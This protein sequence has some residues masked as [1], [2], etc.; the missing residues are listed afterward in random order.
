MKLA[1]SKVLQF[2]NFLEYLLSKFSFS[3]PNYHIE[4]IL[5]L[6]LD[7]IVKLDHLLERFHCDVFL[8]KHFR[9]ECLRT[10]QGCWIFLIIDS[11]LKECVIALSVASGHLDLSNPCSICHVTDAT[12]VHLIDKKLWVF[13]SRYECLT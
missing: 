2:H 1:E 13:H 5:E 12:C 9:N 3:C 11:V 7:I 10:K 4:L 6:I 8:I